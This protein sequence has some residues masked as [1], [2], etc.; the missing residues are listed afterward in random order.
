MEQITKTKQTK[1]TPVAPEESTDGEVL[2]GV[3]GGGN[4]IQ[5]ILY[6]K[7]KIPFP[8]KENRKK[9]RINKIKQKL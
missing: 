7:K 6:E 9:G 8:P 5:D 4:N 1:K 3:E 2:E